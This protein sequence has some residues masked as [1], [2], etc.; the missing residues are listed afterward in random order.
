VINT[1]Y[2]Y[3]IINMTETRRASA[4]KKEQG[5][6]YTNCQCR[7]PV[8]CF[9]CRKIK[10]SSC[11]KQLIRTCYTQTKS[12]SFRRTEGSR[13]AR[14]SKKQPQLQKTEYWMINILVCIDHNTSSD[15]ST[16]NQQVIW[17]VIAAE[18]VINTHVYR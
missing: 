18:D 3:Y 6:K 7:V 13:N 2:T 12:H 8:C 4:K 16:L 11:F 17:E 1:C 15:I 5:Q 10:A 9:K 14:W